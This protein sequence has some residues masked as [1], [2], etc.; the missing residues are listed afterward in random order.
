M[1]VPPEALVAANVRAKAHIPSPRLPRKYSLRNSFFLSSR[2]ADAAMTNMPIVYATNVHSAA[3]PAMAS[4][5]W[6][7]RAAT[8]RERG[9]QT[10]R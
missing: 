8:V 10:A 3:F 9:N 1:N 7:L 4:V 6:Q 2:P 5:I